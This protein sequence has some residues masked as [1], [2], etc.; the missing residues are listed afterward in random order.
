MPGWSDLSRG[1]LLGRPAWTRARIV[2]ETLRSETVGGFLLLASAIIALLWAN[3]PWRSGYAK[4]IDASFGLSE[5]HLRLTVAEWASDGLLA[6]FFFVVGL[7]L[8]REFVSGDLRSP[9]RA[10]LPIMAAVGGMVAPALIYLTV[11]AVGDGGAP[12]GWAVPTATDI[13][14]AVAVLAVISTHLPVA[15]RSF[16]LTLA[17]VDDLLAVTIIA[18]FFTDQLHPLPLLGALATIAAFGL[19]ARRRVN[20]WLLLP[21][22]VAAWALMHASGVHATIAGVLLGFAVPALTRRAPAL[23]RRAPARTGA[24]D[25]DGGPS[26]SER[27]EHRWRPISAGVAVP[28]F[29]LT[30]AG[31]AV[32]GA[33][34]GVLG[35]LR[36]PAGAGVALGLILGKPIGILAATL[37]LARFTR[38]SLDDELSWWDVLGLSMLAGVGFTV[39]LL[40]G[41]LAFG[42]GSERADHVRTAILLGSVVSAILAAM[43]LRWRNRVYRRICEQEAVDADA[44]GIPDVY[45]QR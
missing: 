42:A 5:L 40:I 18:V 44:D 11:N 21:L 37:A 26:P 39:S 14:F 23:T 1:T 24:C 34:G 10:A 13:A 28:L 16:L 33:G 41:D 45:Q 15:L 36:D 27:L 6:I 35:A 2:A 25:P 3:S 38:A 17:V 31:V 9:H 43:V 20:G 19:L 12:Q 22:G 7:E 30:A 4:L 8:K 29:A 32:T